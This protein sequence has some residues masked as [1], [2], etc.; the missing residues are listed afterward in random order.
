MCLGIPMQIDAI[1]GYTARCSAKGVSREVSTFLM[2]GEPLEV[3][4]FV[5][6]HVGYAIQK[7][8]PQEAQST[9]ELLDEMLALED[10]EARQAQTASE[11]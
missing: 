7:V 5:I 10:Q 4:D 1:D 8:S 9:W 6:V 11:P 3:G 2:Q